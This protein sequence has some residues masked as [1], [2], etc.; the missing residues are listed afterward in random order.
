MLGMLSD[1][2]SFISTYILLVLSSPDSAETDIGWG[3]ILNNHLMASCAR[4]I[5]TKN[6]LKTDI[7]SSN[8]NR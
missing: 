8:D 3:R 1:V 6:Y 7:L 4:N 2:F 5:R